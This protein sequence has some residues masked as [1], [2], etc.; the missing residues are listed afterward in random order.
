LTVLDI[1][2]RVVDEEHL[3]VQ[4]TGRARGVQPQAVRGAQ[5]SKATTGVEPV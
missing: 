4:R 5:V 2:L 3:V 1:N